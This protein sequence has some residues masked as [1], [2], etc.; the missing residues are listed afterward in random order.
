MRLILPSLLSQMSYRTSIV[1]KSLLSQMSYITYKN[2]KWC[3]RHHLIFNW[4]SW[5]V[6]HRRPTM[7]RNSIYSLDDILILTCSRISTHYFTRDLLIFGRSNK[8]TL[9]SYPFGMTPWP[10]VKGE[11]LGGCSVRPYWSVPMSGRTMLSREIEL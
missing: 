2:K 6:S 8:S 4:W 7:T 9:F 11:N 5:S 3:M 1:I 10:S